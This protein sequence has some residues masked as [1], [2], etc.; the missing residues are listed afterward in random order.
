MTKPKKNEHNV[1][2]PALA[3]LISDKL[4][5]DFNDL[6]ALVTKSMTDKA[7]QNDIERIVIELQALQK[8]IQK[9]ERIFP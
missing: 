4:I 3:N 5:A 9:K 1:L 7:I 6:C 2:D 8:T